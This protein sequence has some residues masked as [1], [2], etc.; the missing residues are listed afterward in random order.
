MFEFQLTLPRLV[1]FISIRRHFYVFVALL[2]KNVHL[3]KLQSSIPWLQELK[4]TH[5]CIIL[6]LT[7]MI[8]E[9]SSSGTGSGHFE[10]MH[11]NPFLATN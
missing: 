2:H 11:K 6:K 4:T 1:L 9:N 10:L 8:I 7:L 3:I 5:I